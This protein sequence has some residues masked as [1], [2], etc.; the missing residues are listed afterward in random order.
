MEHKIIEWIRRILIKTILPFRK[1][2]EKFLSQF[3]FSIEFRISFQYA[4]LLIIIGAILFIPTAIVVYGSELRDYPLV[5]HYREKTYH[6]TIVTLYWWAVGLYSFLLF[7]VIKWGKKNIVKLLEPIDEMTKTTNH[8]SV[9]NLQQE[10]LNIE[11]T[12]NE[13]KDLA[14]T[15]NCMLDRIELSYESQKQFVSDASHELRTPIAVIQGYVN[16]LDRWGKKDKEV[17]EESID[18][19]KNE[20]QAM[21]ELVEKLLFLSR[22]DKKTLKLTKKKFNMKDAVEDMWKETKMVAKQRNIEQLSM[23]DCLVYGDKQSLKQAVRVFIDNAAKYTKE[24]DTIYIGCVNEEK[25]CIITI[26]DTGLGMTQKDMNNIFERFYRSDQ[27]RNEKISGHG[28]G[29]SIAKLIILKHAGSIE[30][31]SQ[32]TRG[33]CFRILIPKRNF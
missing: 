10:R 9:N 21:Q 19:I 1:R 14:S 18:A 29:L 25:N 15:I 8:L 16:L 26:A 5:F 23:E 28:L 7:I 11:G 22:H 31:K 30:V 4:W 2:K 13:L 33:T 20:A 24:G 3:R 27:V 12:K 6:T 32:Y 17:M